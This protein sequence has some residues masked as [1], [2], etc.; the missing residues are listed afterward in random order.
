MA[1]A[2]RP[3]S[4]ICRR[5]PPLPPP[6]RSAPSP[7]AI[8]GPGDTLTPRSS[9]TDAT[10]PLNASRNSLSCLGAMLMEAP[11]KTA[12]KWKTH[13]PSKR[14]GARG[15][16]APCPAGYER[17][18]ASSQRASCGGGVPR[19]RTIQLFRV[20]RRFCFF[21][22]RGELREEN[23]ILERKERERKEGR[24]RGATRGV[25]R[26]R[27]KKRREKKLPRIGPLAAARSRSFPPL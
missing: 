11:L 12:S 16:G 13:S 15:A 20:F 14:E 22:G 27:A 3:A 26:K 9:C 21:W 18:R 6:P 1:S 19:Q 8:V 10:L 24:R 23:E 4:P 5:L 25:E 17:A 2:I 7:L